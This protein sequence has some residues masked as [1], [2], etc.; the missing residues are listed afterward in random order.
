MNRIKRWVMGTL[1]VDD[2][3][4]Y[5]HEIGI[6]LDFTFQKKRQIKYYAKNSKLYKVKK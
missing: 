4:I 1:T 3:V 6:G 5:F 2:L